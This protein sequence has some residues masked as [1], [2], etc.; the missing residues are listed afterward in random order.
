MMRS[1]EIYRGST[2]QDALVTE[3]FDE[4]K[5]VG[6]LVWAATWWDENRVEPVRFFKNLDEA[7]ALCEAL[8]RG[9]SYKWKSYRSG[10]G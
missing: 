1:V 9:T 10:G 7:I 3:E 5:V 6:Y 4:R 8:D 2:K